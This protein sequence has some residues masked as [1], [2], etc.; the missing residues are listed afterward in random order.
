MRKSQVLPSLLLTLFC[1]P[2]VA[3]GQINIG[4]SSDPVFVVEGREATFDVVLTPT[5]GETVDAFTL[6]F[7]IG[8]GGAATGSPQDGDNLLITN[9]EIGILA[10][11]TDFTAVVT[12]GGVGQS[13]VLINFNLAGDSSGLFADG[14]VATITVDSSSANLG[15]S[16][17][18]NPNI[19]EETAFFNA[20]VP[21][22]FIS[23][24][25]TLRIEGA[26]LGDVNLDGVVDFSDIF[27]FI[28]VLTA[29][30]F[31]EEADLNQ[32]DAVNFLDISQFITVLMNS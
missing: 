2:V 23:S 10:D 19:L 22:P 8:D 12:T 9:L 28:E 16:F 32:D 3:I 15:D 31:Q 30:G 24:S 6:A 7:A 18:L 29:G 5:A 25:S 20:G 26:L 17:V 27:A 4:I 21:V 14:V 13:A 11:A 1:F